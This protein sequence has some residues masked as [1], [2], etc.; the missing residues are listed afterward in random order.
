M[1]ASVL[2]VSHERPCSIYIADV[3]FARR[4]RNGRVFA[5]EPLYLQ[6]AMPMPGYCSEEAKLPLVIFIPGGGY[7]NPKM[8][9]RVPWA[10]RLA[11]RGF[12]VAMPQYRGAE[13]IPFPGQIE[14]VLTA[15]RFLRANAEKYAIDPHRVVLLGGSAGAHIALL[16]AY[17]GDRFHAPDDD[18]SVSAAVSGVIDLYGPVDGRGMVPDDCSEERAASLPTGKLVGG[19]DIRKH[20]EAV[21]PTVVTNYIKKGTALPPTLIL[22]GS[23]DSVV[24][25]SQSVLLANALEDAGQDVSFCCIDNAGHATPEFFQPEAIDL[26]E[27]FIRRVTGIS[28]A[29]N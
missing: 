17:G 11:E 26:Y 3:E 10:A 14:D 1:E 2:R 28:G 7:M 22:H 4:L 5:Q 23:A 15:V 25:Y 27:S 9:W 18:L 8:Y 12:V 16:A 13:E 19:L 29:Q 21:F 24:P 6:M 20:P